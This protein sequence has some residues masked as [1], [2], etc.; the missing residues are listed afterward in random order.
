[1]P[2]VEDVHL[3]SLTAHFYMHIDEVVLH[4]SPCHFSEGIYTFGASIWS[5]TITSILG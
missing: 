1:M 5:S 3:R 2:F 4:T